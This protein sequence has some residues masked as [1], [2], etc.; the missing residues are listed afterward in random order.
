MKKNVLIL[1]VSLFFLSCNTDRLNV[2]R[3]KAQGTTYTISYIGNERDNLKQSLDSIFQVID[4]SMSNYREDSTISRINNGEDIAVDQHFK[5]V[6]LASQ[7]V[8]NQSDGYFDPSI[9]QL[10][11]IWGFG[12]RKHT[13]AP[14]KQTIDSLLVGTGMNKIS[15]TSDSHL[16]KS[17]QNIKLNFNAIAQGYTC[18][19]IASFLKS[20]GYSDF[21][22]EVGGELFICGRNSIKNKPWTIGI[23]NPLQSDEK[24]REI[25]TKLELTDCGLATSGNYRKVWTDSTTG[26]RYVHTINPK[27]GYPQQSDILSA[28]V[29]SSTS[30]FADAYATTLMAIGMERAKTFLSNHPELKYLILY[31]SKD[32]DSQIKTYTNCKIQQ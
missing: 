4:L 10:I 7:M 16:R 14:S 1:F 2:V 18:D 19:V 6:L 17:S 29:I 12:E 24:E 28:T 32:G 27:T 25:I 11:R 21:I 9:G 5:N 13:T 15:L 20:L 22:V 30:M 31:Q 26:K 8:Y 3:G 23:D